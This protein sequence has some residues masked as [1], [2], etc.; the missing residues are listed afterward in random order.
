MGGLLPG[1]PL[2]QELFSIRMVRT[3]TIEAAFLLAGVRRI[4]QPFMACPATRAHRGEPGL[5]KT[6]YL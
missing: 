6:K 3:V 2:Q 5:S 1:I 4:T